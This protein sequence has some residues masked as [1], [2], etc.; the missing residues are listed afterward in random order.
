MLRNPLGDMLGTVTC[1]EVMAKGGT[2]KDMAAV[3]PLE[4]GKSDDTIV[5][6]GNSEVYC[7]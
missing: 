3:C 2:A 6:R 4:C 1:G 5:P 7:T